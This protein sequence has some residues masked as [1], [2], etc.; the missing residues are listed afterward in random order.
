MSSQSV[1]KWGNSL[2]FRIPAAIARQMKVAE[3]AKVSIEVVGSKLVVQAIEELPRFTKAD[4][5]KAVKSVKLR[6]D[7]L[8]SAKGREIL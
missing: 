6:K 7:P 2:A 1:L 5:S 8:G 4:L 3:G